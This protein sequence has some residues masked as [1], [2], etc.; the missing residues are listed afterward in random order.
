MD[1]NC[2]KCA[3]PV[4]V[5]YLH[6]VADIDGEH[7]DGATFTDILRAFQTDGCSALGERCRTDIGDADR[8]R[9]AGAALLFDLLGDDVDGIAATLEDFEAFGVL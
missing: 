3:E 2:P 7:G 8:A 4:E 6:E 9:A 5:D 1:I